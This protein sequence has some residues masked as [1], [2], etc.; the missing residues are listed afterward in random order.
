M[1][2]IFRYSNLLNILLRRKGQSLYTRILVYNPSKIDGTVQYQTTTR[3]CNQS[4]PSPFRLRRLSRISTL[5]LVCMHIWIS[6]TPR[7]AS[8]PPVTACHW[9]HYAVDRPGPGAGPITTFSSGTNDGSLRLKSWYGCIPD[10]E[11]TTRRSPQSE[12]GRWDSLHVWCG[13]LV[14]NGNI[15]LG[16]IILVKLLVHILDRKYT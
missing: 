7:K 15:D 9:R 14:L 5:Y 6:R 4:R 3:R 8:E 11:L 1:Y 16:G 10:S 2:V 13:G 12:R